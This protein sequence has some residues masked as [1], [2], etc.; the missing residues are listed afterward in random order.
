VSFKLGLFYTRR[1]VYFGQLPGDSDLLQIQ[2]NV[3][4]ALGRALFDIFGTSNPQFT[5]L[6]VTPGSGF[7]VN[8]GAGSLYQQIAAEATAW[9]SPTTGLPIDATV[10]TKQGRSDSA[11]SNQFGTMVAPGSGTNSAR[12]GRSST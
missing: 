6:T 12:I 7:S 3:Q 1:T 9:G 10:I 2:S 4:K 8:I 11:L 5:G